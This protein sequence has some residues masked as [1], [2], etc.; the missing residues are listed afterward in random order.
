MNWD[1]TST[2][3]LMR[4]PERLP[5]GP[6]LLTSFPMKAS[7]SD[8]WLR[9]IWTVKRRPQPACLCM[10][11]TS[12]WQQPPVLQSLRGLL[13]LKPTCWLGMVCFDIHVE[14]WDLFLY[15]MDLGAIVPAGVASLWCANR[16]RWQ[17]GVLK[18]GLYQIYN[19]CL[20]PAP[21]CRNV[22]K[23]FEVIQFPCCWP[24]WFLSSP[25]NSWTARCFA[26][27][28]P[29]ERLQCIR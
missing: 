18:S 9:K 8:P 21:T 14:L 23:L 2:R 13:F 4:R 3:I 5:F 1:I 6:M 26:D 7:T 25:L 27:D 17:P 29:P 12:A 24:P 19:I 28:R 15:T 10:S 16:T 20:T 11:R 22:C